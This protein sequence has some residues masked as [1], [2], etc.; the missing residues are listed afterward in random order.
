MK[1]TTKFVSLQSKRI[2]NNYETGIF[3]SV[4]FGM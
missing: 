3:F 4:F 1:D 2:K